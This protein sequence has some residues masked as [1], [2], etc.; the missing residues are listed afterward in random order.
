MDLDCSGTSLAANRSEGSL[1]SGETGTREAKEGRGGD[2]G[3]H[4]P[5][6]SLEP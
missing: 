6:L 1:A 2:E 5:A 3:V 4:L